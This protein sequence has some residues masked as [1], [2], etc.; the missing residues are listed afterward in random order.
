M[1]EFMT[2]TQSYCFCSIPE[3]TW[4]WSGHMATH[5]H[6]QCVTKHLT[7][8]RLPFAIFPDSFPRKSVG[9]LTQKLARWCHLLR[10]LLWFLWWVWIRKVLFKIQAEFWQRSFAAVAFTTRLAPIV[11]TANLLLGSWNGLFSATSLTA[12][13]MTARLIWLFMGWSPYPKQPFRFQR[14]WLKKKSQNPSRIIVISGDWLQNILCC[15][16]SMS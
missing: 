15:K 3:V 9:K 10:G 5:L 6:L 11:H 14:D 4:L 1:K 12:K 13:A 16:H 8:M 2:F 7:I